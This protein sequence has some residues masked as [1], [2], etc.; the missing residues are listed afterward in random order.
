MAKPKAIVVTTNARRYRAFIKDNNLNMV[1]YPW[2]NDKM[3]LYGYKDTLAFLVTG[4]QDVFGHGMEMNH[5][6]VVLK[7]HNVDTIRV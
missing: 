4:W 2:A 1:D 5:T 3:D 6:E 7:N